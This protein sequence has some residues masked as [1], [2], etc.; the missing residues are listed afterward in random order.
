MEKQWT[1]IEL[2]GRTFLYQEVVKMGKQRF[3]KSANLRFDVQ[4]NDI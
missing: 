1:D 3:W 4:L 2:M